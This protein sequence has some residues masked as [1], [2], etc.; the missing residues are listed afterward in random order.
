MFEAFSTA[1]HFATI[2]WKRSFPFHGKK[3]VLPYRFLFLRLRVELSSTFMPRWILSLCRGI[4]S[5][6]TGVEPSSG[7]WKIRT[8]NCI[9]LPTMSAAG[10]RPDLLSSRQYFTE[11]ASRPFCVSHG[12]TKYEMKR[13]DWS[14][15]WILHVTAEQS[16][17]GT[18]V[19]SLP[20]H[21]QIILAVALKIGLKDIDPNAV[22]RLFE[23]KVLVATVKRTS[24]NDF[25]QRRQTAE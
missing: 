8:E 24:S 19:G 20:N 4:Q 21:Y 22:H 1:P 17:K 7:K 18:G 3:L 5:M 16:W 11:P 2:H 13:H 14:I 25:Y 15:G 6:V 9:H 12:E 10:Q 23:M